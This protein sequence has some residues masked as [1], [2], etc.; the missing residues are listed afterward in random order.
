MFYII[1]VK[2]YIICNFEPMNNT[3]FQLTVI[4]NNSDYEDVAFKSDLLNLNYKFASAF[5]IHHP[6]LQRFLRFP[7]DEQESANKRIVFRHFLSLVLSKLIL[8]KRDHDFYFPIDMDE[9]FTSLIKCSLDADEQLHIQFGVIDKVGIGINV[10]TLE[11]IGEVPKAFIPQ[12]ANVECEK[13]E[14]VLAISENLL[15][16]NYEAVSFTTKLNSN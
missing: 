16:L 10:T 14:L 5:Y 1:K 4:K 15:H 13:E 7:D 8:L 9:D 3:L 11:L 2:A 12:T 6:E